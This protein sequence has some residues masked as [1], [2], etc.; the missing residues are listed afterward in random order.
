MPR[1]PRLELQGVPLHV[2]QR[3]TNKG[4]IFI[5]DDDRHDFRRLLRSAFNE[6]G[7]DLHAFV[8][9]DN[10]FHLLVTPHAVGVLSSAMRWIG[11]NYVQA[12]NLRHGRCGTLWQGRFKS[13]L[14]QTDQ[15]LLT[16][17]RYIELNPV[18][19][20]MAMRPEDFRWSSVHTHL[21]HANDPLV[22]PHPLYL[23]MGEDA[24]DRANAYRAWLDAGITTEE[25]Q[26][27]RTYAQQE[28]VLGDERFQRMVE[29]TLGR[30]A[31][32]RPR[33]RPRRAASDEI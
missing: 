15:Y 4:A 3:G 13:C 9:M 10:H 32:S 6:H 26:R 23:A 17:M 2:T 18:R 29:T 33:G 25:L 1:L 19:A 24:W 22:T 28:R 8:L 12:F 14:V 5:D 21:A 31:V 11:Q 30:P 16:V 7:I 20:A 27:L